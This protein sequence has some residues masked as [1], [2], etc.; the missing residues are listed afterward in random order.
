MCDM[1]CPFDCGPNAHCLSNYTMYFEG[2][3]G[4]C[5][6]DQGYGR[7]NTDNNCTKIIP[8]TSM[9]LNKINNNF[10]IIFSS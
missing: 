6:C 7:N 3:D 8:K 1:P 9:A 10:S 5:R 2:D 4:F